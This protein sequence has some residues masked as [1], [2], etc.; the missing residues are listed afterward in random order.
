MYERGS[1]WRQ[2][3]L[4][5]HTPASF[6]WSGEKFNG[7]EAHD[8]QLVDAMI[9]AMNDAA[10]AAFA[11]MDYWTFDGWFALQRRL[12]EAGAPALTKAVFPGIEIRLV[13]PMKTAGRSLNA[14]VIFSEKVP[15]QLLRDFQSKL[16]I[17]IAN[18]P[19]SSDGLMH[20]ARITDEDHLKVHGAKKA[21][22][23]DDAR[24]LFVGQSIAEVTCES[25]R[26]AI[27]HVGEELAVG[28]MPYDTSDGLKDVKW[29][30]QYAFFVGLFKTSPI[31][32]SRNSNLRD[33]FLGIETPA[34][35]AFIKQFQERLGG[36][37]RLVVS[38]SDAHCFVG[39]SGDNN[40]RGYGDFP[41]GKITWIK[42]DPTFEGLR[43]AIREPAK[44]SFIGAKPE[45]QAEL[46]ANKTFFMDRIAVDRVT[47][48]ASGGWLHGTDIPLNPDLVAV[49]G[50]RGSGKSALA[51]ILALTGNSRQREHFSFLKKDRF[52][53]KVGDPARDF[54]ATLTWADG[55][56]E[57]RNLYEKAPSTKVEMVRYI[58]QGHFEA[59][60]NAHV[61]GMSNAFEQELRGVIFAH[62]SDE[63]RLGALDFDQLIDKQEEGLR[64]KLIE[65]RATLNRISQSIT[66]VEGQL[67]PDVKLQLEELLVVKN[68]QIEEIDKI[69][70]APAS[71]P[72]ETLTPEQQT[73]AGRLEEIGKLLT[74]DGEQGKL[75]AAKN[76]ELVAK[77]KSV[78]NVEE[79]LEALERAHARFIADTTEDL[80]KLGLGADQLVDLKI[81]KE[82]LAVIAASIPAEQQVIAASSQTAAER[83]SL[84]LDE[85]RKLTA[86]LDAPQLAYQQALLASEAWQKKRDELVGE[87]GVPESLAGLI[88][89][90]AQI[91]A[92]PARLEELR[93]QRSVVSGGIFDVLEAQRVARANLFAP[94]Q[95]VIGGDVLIRDDYRLQFRASLGGSIDSLASSLMALIK[96]THGV[97]RGSGEGHGV[98][99]D[100]VDLHDLNTRAGALGFVEALHSAVLTAAQEAR[101]ASVGVSAI[102]KKDR[103][104]SDVYD[105]IFGLS[106]LEPRY[107]LLFQDTQIE[108]LSP[109]QRG[110]LLLIFY[111]LVDKG[112]NPIILD[113]PEE[114][115]DNETVVK[116]LVPVISKAKKRRQIIMVTHNPNL[117]VV[118]DAEQIICSSF[119]RKSDSK[120]SYISGSIENPLINAHVVNI[121]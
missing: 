96:Q 120:I 60:C 46:E 5:V 74:A 14:H 121:L 21:E 85:Q 89:R 119:D 50:N 86:S 39:R 2:W 22:L 1:E 115:L 84:L 92:L 65:L 98:I 114:N 88:A 32:E 81:D 110:A 47:S 61:T 41:S 28:F 55:S 20:L 53:G 27:A 116:L 37:P 72:T 87:A 54:E 56:S 73:A 106:F 71:K 63:I 108:Q 9:K 26:A 36:I 11:L 93:R 78:K 103:V 12:K 82:P 40:K 100:L 99:N 94:V 24:A 118:C 117:A 67:Q 104:A 43:Q 111:L 62:T 59:L 80:T 57:P 33:C 31:F 66:T 42:A 10:P 68:K 69:K 29:E 107:S 35:K 95:D 51:D 58:P 79:R 8:R 16:E 52:W 64:T 3:D 112:Q 15:D 105:L 34:N 97:F 44:R 13:A 7:I 48:K 4:H 109:G 113:Q 6:H 25:Y 19:L 83:V 70:P 76:L 23:T 17:A 101:P 49:I 30:E 18:R 45:K 77:A 91:D 90:I 102:L 38:G 75:R